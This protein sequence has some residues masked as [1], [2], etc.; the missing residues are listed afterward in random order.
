MELGFWEKDSP[1][2]LVPPLPR[3]NAYNNPTKENK[4]NKFH[5]RRGW[6]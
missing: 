6:N 4:K 1:S 5:L 2:P 3:W